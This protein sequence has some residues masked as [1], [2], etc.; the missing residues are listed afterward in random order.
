M[1]STIFIHFTD[2]HLVTAASADATITA[3]VVKKVPDIH[4]YIN[5]I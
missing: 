3:E 5:S 2:S 1:Q 4:F